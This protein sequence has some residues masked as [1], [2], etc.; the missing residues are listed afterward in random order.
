MARFIASRGK[1]AVIALASTLGSRS[2]PE[3]RGLHHGRRARTRGQFSL[4]PTALV[5]TDTTER[6]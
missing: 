3:L 5:R 2:T 1:E 6:V 4:P